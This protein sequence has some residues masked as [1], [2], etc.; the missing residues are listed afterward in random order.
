MTRYPSYI[1]QNTFH[2][3]ETGRQPSYQI[4]L[5]IKGTSLAIMHQRSISPKRSMTHLLALHVPQANYEMLYLSMQEKSLPLSY[6]RSPLR[7]KSPPH[8]TAEPLL[9]MLTG[10]SRN[11]DVEDLLQFPHTLLLP[12]FLCPSCAV[13]AASL[14]V[15]SCWWHVWFC[16]RHWAFL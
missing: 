4:K 10:V 13:A 2:Y 3:Q 12:D 15:G 9:L 16:W 14:K 6:K 5:P 7:R 1:W 8:S 11:S